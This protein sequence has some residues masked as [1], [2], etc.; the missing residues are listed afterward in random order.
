MVLS[1]TSPTAR[2]FTHCIASKWLSLHANT[3]SDYSSPCVEDGRRFFRHFTI[4]DQP[5][6]PL[7]I[8]SDARVGSFQ[9][10]ILRKSRC[11]TSVQVGPGP[12][13]LVPHA[14]L[15]SGSLPIL[16]EVHRSLGL[17]GT[18]DGSVGQHH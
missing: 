4:R 10:R 6:R 13:S 2:N 16:P 18:M 1:H 14:A 11:L 17:A 5:D 3:P 9:V 8:S 7:P 12:S 15:D